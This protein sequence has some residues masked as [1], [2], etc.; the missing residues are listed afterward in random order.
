[1]STTN[2]DNWNS[3]AY[4][5]NASFVADLAMPVVE[6][7][8]PQAGERILDLGCGDGRLTQKLAELGCHVIG[9]DASADMI[10]AAKALGLDA[11]VLD[12]QDLL[13]DNEFDAVFSNAA[14]HWMKS[15]QQ[16]V[17][18]VYR[19]LK[20][21]G[22]FVGEFG[23]HGNVATI[24]AALESALNAR[25]LS[26]PEPWYY[27]RAEEYR[28]LLE[29]QGFKVVFIDTIPRPTELPGDV[30]GWLQTFAQ[31]YTSLIA[32]QDRQQFIAQLVNDL[33]ASLCDDQGVWRADYV[34]L[35]FSAIKGKA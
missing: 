12:G 34:R 7:L 16:V 18:G 25:G 28:S 14:L 23:A 15:Q 13:F 2:D 11:R 21:G 22:R 9:V 19:A 33:R 8:S 5:K 10:K 26:I 6:L 1:M 35:R 29:T 3:Q 30:G 27:P 20:A 17:A 4:V 32:K 31:A 24:V